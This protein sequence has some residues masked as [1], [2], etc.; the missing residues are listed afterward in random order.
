MKTNSALFLTFLS[1][2]SLAQSF[3]KT[4]IIQNQRSVSRKYGANAEIDEAVQKIKIATPKGSVVVIKYGGHAM[5]NDEYKNLF[6]NDIATLCKIGILPVIVHGGGPQIAAMLKSLNIESKFIGGLRVTDAKTLEVAQMV[7]CGSIN[8]ELCG[9]LSSLD[10]IRGAIGL[11]GLDGKLI[12]A[13]KITKTAINEAT[14]KEEVI[15]IGLVVDPVSCNTGPFILFAS[16][17]PYIYINYLT[18]IVE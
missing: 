11:S 9:K 7:L 10:G 15:D 14:G 12:N 4:S 2:I 17:R 3:L 18:C 1:L 5:E 6:C 8:K 13:K 16:R